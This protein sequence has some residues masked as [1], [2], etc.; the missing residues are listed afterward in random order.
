[1][2]VPDTD[3]R[4]TNAAY[5]PNAANRTRELRAC[6]IVLSTPRVATK[7]DLTVTAPETG[8]IVTGGMATWNDVSGAGTRFTLSLTPKFVAMPEPDPID[9]LLGSAVEPP[10]DQVVLGTLYIV[11]PP[12]PPD[13][14]DF[15]PD[16]SWVPYAK[17]TDYGFWNLG[18]ATQRPPPQ[19]DTTPLSLVTGIPMA[20][21]LIPGFLAPTNDAFSAIAD[22]FNASSSKGTFYTAA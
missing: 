6:D 20:D 18:Y 15:V 5:D 21:M 2:G 11:S 13:G 3:S 1:M 22:F 4:S 8:S 9:W 16:G 19:I 14:P 10:L 12:N 7:V 17:Y